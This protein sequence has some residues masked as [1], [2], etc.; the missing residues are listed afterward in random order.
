MSVH[1]Y[2]TH[3]VADLD[4]WRPVFD[5]H[6]ASRKEHGCLSE[7]VYQRSGD[8]NSILV[9]MEYPTRADADA[10]LADPSL[11]EA[12]GRA[13]VLAQPEVRFSED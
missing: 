3:P 4:A 12:M 7:A 10:F 8:P 13:G 9:V 1:V 5:E 11:A 6:G 2:V